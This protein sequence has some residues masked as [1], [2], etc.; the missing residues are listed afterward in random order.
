M[1]RL[2]TFSSIAALALVLTSC[3]SQNKVQVGGVPKWMMEGARIGSEP[4]AMAPDPEMLDYKDE[5]GPVEFFMITD[6]RNYPLSPPKKVSQVE[7]IEYERGRDSRIK[8]LF[9]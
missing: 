2:L 8:R 7:E 1:I 9:R 4:A 5:S 3:S 6:I